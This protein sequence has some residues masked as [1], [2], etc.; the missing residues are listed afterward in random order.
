MILLHALL[1]DRD[2]WRC[3]TSHLTSRHPD[4]RVL[5]T[6][7]ADTAAPVA[8]APS[9]TPSGNSPV[10]STPSSTRRRDGTIDRLLCRVGCAP[11]HGGGDGPGAGVGNGGSG[12]DHG[13][14]SELGDWLA[15]SRWSWSVWSRP[16][17]I[18]R[19]ASA[20]RSAAVVVD[21]D[22][23]DR[24]LLAFVVSDEDLADYLDRH[25]P[26]YMVPRA[27][28]TLTSC[29]CLRTERWT[30]PPCVQYAQSS[31]PTAAGPPRAD[32][33]DAIAAVWTEVLRVDRVGV[34]QSFFEL[35]GH[36]LL[37]MQVVSR[38]RKEF[39]IEL[40]LRRMFEPPSTIEDLAPAVVESRI[41][42]VDATVAKEELEAVEG[43]S[44]DGVDSQPGEA[45]G[46]TRG[47]GYQ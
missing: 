28:F 41:S 12:G 35:G 31:R 29:R 25:L 16:E 3:Q 8:A 23:A 1:G 40:S 7:N 38:L 19:P 33:E 20:V 30:G 36:S 5:P 9:A 45:A 10:T 47:P 32:T 34:D 43:L 18:A 39:G 26:S 21:G 14:L 46:R 37:A 24:S 15:A 13:R 22:G 42:A 17:C 6:T 2:S 4:I 11:G 44:D 27:L